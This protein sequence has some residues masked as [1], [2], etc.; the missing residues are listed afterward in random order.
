MNLLYKIVATSFGAGYLPIAPGTWGA[1]VGCLPLLAYHAYTTAS[2]SLLFWTIFALIIAGV[3]A[4][5]ALAARKLEPAWGKDPSRIVLDETVG[6]WIAL[7]MIPWT[8]Y[9]VVFGF[10]LF[11]FF[12]I[13]KPLGIRRLE[14]VPN[15]WGV[16]L[17]DVLAGVYSN[18]CLQ[19]VLVL[20]PLL[21][22]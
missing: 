17:D 15:G 2:Y 10:L 22:N 1:V 20:W 4:L 21:S 7:W 6:V 14:K 16:M 18:I 11:R 12:D 13:A 19:I 5:G 3:T 8:T 9:H